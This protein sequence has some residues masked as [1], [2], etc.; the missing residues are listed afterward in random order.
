MRNCLSLIKQRL[1]K[2]HHKDDV[3]FERELCKAFDVFGQRISSLD[4][5]KS[6]SLFEGHEQRNELI[7]T[8][9]EQLSKALELLI[10][11][12]FVLAFIM[13]F[14]Y[15]FA[16]IGGSVGGGKGGGKTR[17]TVATTNIKGTAK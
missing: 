8:I 4:V 12:S 14:R 7:D 3:S 2:V 1:Q 9:T 16:E 17:T 6:T 11:N 10:I 15:Q 13:L 5:P